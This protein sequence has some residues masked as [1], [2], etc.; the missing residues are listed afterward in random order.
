[1]LI[2]RSAALSTQEETLGFML[3]NVSRLMRRD[4]ERRLQGT[5]LTLAQA[6]ALVYISRH[7]GI[8]QV[9]LA[10]LLEIQPITLVRLIDQLAEAGLI[11]RRAD[12]DDRR[13]YQV[14]LTA[15]A[16]PQLAVVKR[17]TAATRAR[18][19]RGLD[20]AEAA[21]VMAA[22]QRMRSNLAATE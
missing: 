7:E 11:E 9:D 13:A 5:P 19:L 2:I 22:L 18:A 14:Y 16:A 20:A 15:A 1:L 17:A 4:F 8:R 10:E 3:A 12:P 21:A 6:R